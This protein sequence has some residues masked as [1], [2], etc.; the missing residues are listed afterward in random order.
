MSP[1]KE[2]Q[3]IRSQEEALIALENQLVDLQ[4]DLPF[5]R[6]RFLTF[7]A[8]FSLVAVLLWPANGMPSTQLEWILFACLVA[9]S[10]VVF[11]LLG[12]G[13]V[14]ILRQQA[15]LESQIRL[16]RVALREARESEEEPSP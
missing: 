11:L 7:S 12:V 2:L 15:R 14:R 3:E 16:T 4:H 10:L 8:L 6:R 5:G 1:S 9:L 13:L